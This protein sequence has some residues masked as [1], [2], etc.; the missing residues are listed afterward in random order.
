M[1]CSVCRSHFNSEEICPGK[2]A[3]Y[4]CQS[5]FDKK[6]WAK[7]MLSKH[8]LCNR[9]LIC[10]TCKDLGH[11]SRDIYKYRCVHC[12]RY[13][14]YSMFNK[15]VLKNFKARGSPLH[16][17]TCEKKCECV[18]CGHRFEKNW[19]H[20]KRNTHDICQECRHNGYTM[21][22]TEK[23]TCAE[24][25]TTAGYR[26]FVRGQTYYKTIGSNATLI[27]NECSETKPKKKCKS[28]TCEHKFDK[29]WQHKKPENHD[30]CHRCEENGYKWMHSEA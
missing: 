30:I 23:Y 11:T 12:N 13:L 18:T 29:N 7:P 16:C 6:E 25:K 22:H 5:I 21:I 9:K 17:L 24:C 4:A 15:N 20:M 8:R 19:G 1:M 3:C 28:A 26:K 14:G 10:R 27:C 2:H